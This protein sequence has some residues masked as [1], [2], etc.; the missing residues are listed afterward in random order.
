[1]QTEEKHCEDCGR[2]F[3][4][5]REHGKFCSPLCRLRANRKEKREGKPNAKNE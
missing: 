4:P 3:T 2:E 1:M 5:K